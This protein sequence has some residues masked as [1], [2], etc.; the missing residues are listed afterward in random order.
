MPDFW[1]LIPD[2]VRETSD[3]FLLIDVYFLTSFTG[4][5]I[6]SWDGCGKLAVFSETFAGIGFYGLLPTTF[7]G[8]E[9]TTSVADDCW[10]YSCSPEFYL[11]KVLGTA[12]IIELSPPS[13]SDNLSSFKF[14]SICILTNWACF[15]ASS[16]WRFLSYITWSLCEMKASLFSF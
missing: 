11:F 6:G 5:G 4:D 7:Y 15:N 9:I 16:A 12:V 3:F 2:F 13:S 1:R 14:C 8:L 10:S